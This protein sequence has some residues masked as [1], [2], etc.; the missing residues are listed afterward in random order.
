MEK[1]RKTENIGVDFFTNKNIDIKFSM[2]WGDTSGDKRYNLHDEMAQKEAK[3]KQK[4]SLGQMKRRENTLDGDADV[5]LQIHADFGEKEA[6]T[7]TGTVS[8]GDSDGLNVGRKSHLKDALAERHTKM[9]DREKSLGKRVLAGHQ[10][11]FLPGRRIPK[12]G[13]MIN[14]R[15]FKERRE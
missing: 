8:L 6:K 4:R 1:R 12:L 15:K 2:D 14:E 7:K 11:C 9:H 13:G 5:D 3:S 10:K